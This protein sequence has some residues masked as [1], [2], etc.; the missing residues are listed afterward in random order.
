MSYI[1]YY[2]SVINNQFMVEQNRGWLCQN[3]RKQY[4]TEK[5]AQEAADILNSKLKGD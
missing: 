4:K 1:I 3:E 2:D 5:E